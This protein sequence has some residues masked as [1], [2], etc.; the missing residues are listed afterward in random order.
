MGH[1]WVYWTNAEGPHPPYRGFYPD[2]TDI[3][4]EYEDPKTW[5]RFFAKHSV[6]G[7]CRVDIYAME[8]TEQSREKLRDKKWTIDHEKKD[9]LERICFIP[10]DRISIHKGRYSWN[11]R[12]ADWDNCSSWAIKIV[13]QVMDDA[14]FIICNRPK[15]LQHVVRAIWGE[16]K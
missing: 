1:M 13:N 16:E 4:P 10:E 3:P 15:R 6:R 14:N 7:E 9:R 11:K 2:I 5:P 8:L 12:R